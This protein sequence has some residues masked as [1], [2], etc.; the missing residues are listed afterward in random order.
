ML[1]PRDDNDYVKRYWFLEGLADYWDNGTATV[2]RDTLTHKLPKRATAFGSK[3][4]I[5]AALA[6]TFEKFRSSTLVLSYGSNAVP[7]LDTLVAMVREVKGAAPEV[8]TIPHR[9]HFGTHQS[10]ARREAVEYVLLAA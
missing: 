1:P 7:T 10:A 4:T 8:I 3:R 6:G 2:M 5:V 9:Y